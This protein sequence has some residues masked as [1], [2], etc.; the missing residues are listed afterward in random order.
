[1]P[2]FIV[3]SLIV[4]LSLVTV[5]V[6]VCAYLCAHVYMCVHANV[7]SF[8]FLLQCNCP[9]ITSV[10]DWMLQMK[11]LSSMHG[12]LLCY[13]K[14]VYCVTGNLFIALLEIT[15]CTGSTQGFP[16][17]GKKCL[18][19]LSAARTSHHAGCLLSGCPFRHRLVPQC[20]DTRTFCSTLISNRTLRWLLV[21]FIA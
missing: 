2:R 18:H 8:L 16:G 10:V 17:V 14:L 5:F 6:C 20:C 11:Y 15:T 12:C 19:A 7:H 4:T 21:C 13:W 1:M 3:K 9:E